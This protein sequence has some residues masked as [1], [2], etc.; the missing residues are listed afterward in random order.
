MTDK[1]KTPSFEPVEEPANGPDWTGYG[2]PEIV[3]PSERWMRNPGPG[4]GV[5]QWNEG[6][7]GDEGWALPGTNNDWYGE[8]DLAD[9]EIDPET[10]Y[11]KEGQASAFWPTGAAVD[12]P[13]GGRRV[14]DQQRGMG[15]SGDEIRDRS[16]TKETPVAGVELDEGA[17]LDFGAMNR[18]WHG[19]PVQRPVVSGNVVIRGEQGLAASAM[20][21]VGKAQAARDGVSPHQLEMFR[22]MDVFTP[23]PRTVDR[24][25]DSA[26]LAR[27]RPSGRGA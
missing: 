20:M 18:A 6:V 24:S 8:R 25:V 1:P 11:P 23:G 4:Y 22:P 3:G 19:E 5:Q 2:R 17:R 7:P 12:H 10:K 26:R 14:T 15:L 16:E 21:G 9:H 13:F 27:P